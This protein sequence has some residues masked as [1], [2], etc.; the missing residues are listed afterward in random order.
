M[1]AGIEEYSS[2]EKYLYKAVNALQEK[3]Y[4]TAREHIKHAMIENY[5]APE[6]HNL[7][8]ILAEFTGDLSLAGKHFRAAYALEPTYKPAIKNLERITSYNYRFRNEKPDF[9]DKPEEE[10]IIPYV[11]AYDEKNIGRIKKK[12][13]KK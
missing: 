2:F 11:I 13:Q 5:Q 9:G 1:P 4:D 3:E 8:G 10:E 6:V 12:E 7:F